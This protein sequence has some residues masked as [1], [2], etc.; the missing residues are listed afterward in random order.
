MRIYN[1]DSIASDLRN[2]VFNKTVFSL[3]APPPELIKLITST[4][5][6]YKDMFSL[7]VN[8]VGKILR[9][10]D[11]S[12][13]EIFIDVGKGWEILNYKNASDLMVYVLYKDA[14]LKFRVRVFN[15]YYEF[16][17]ENS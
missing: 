8:R 13:K 5:Y 7:L 14:P 16:E 10:H 2:T 17:T 12:L 3:I 15:T 9:Q 6:D 1:D 11:A 4:V